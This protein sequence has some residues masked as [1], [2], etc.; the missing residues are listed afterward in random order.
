MSIL[1]TIYTRAGEVDGMP[2]IQEAGQ[3]T[4]DTGTLNQLRTYENEALQV[5]RVPRRSGLTVKNLA[6]SARPKTRTIAD[7]HVGRFENCVQLGRTE[8]QLFAPRQPIGPHLGKCILNYRR[9]WLCLGNGS[10]AS[11]SPAPAES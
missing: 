8:T 11:A 4:N 9:Q 5:V 10:S 3:C 1:A 2:V 7:E 6:G